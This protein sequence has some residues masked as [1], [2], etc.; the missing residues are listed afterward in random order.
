GLFHVRA[1]T[2]RCAFVGAS[3]L[4][5][6]MFARPRRDD[7]ADT[8]ELVGVFEVNHTRA[9]LLAE[10]AGIPPYHDFDCM[11]RET[12]PDAVIVSTV[13]RYHHEYIIRALHAG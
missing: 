13:D 3:S 1:P 5:L 7:F 6:S 8:V 11:L 9:E 10:Q 12:R 4:A 2:R